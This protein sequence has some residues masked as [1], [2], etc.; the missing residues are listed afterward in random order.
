MNRRSLLKALPLSVCLAGL[1]K[2]L[3]VPVE[4]GETGSGSVRSQ[5]ALAGQLTARTHHYAALTRV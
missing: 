2:A 5:A 4:P 3:D 1:P